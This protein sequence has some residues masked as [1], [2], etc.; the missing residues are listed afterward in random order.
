M[1]MASDRHQLRLAHETLNMIVTAEMKLKAQFDAH[2]EP[3]QPLS[4]GL[5]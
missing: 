1:L 4:A 2:R 3:L 5:S